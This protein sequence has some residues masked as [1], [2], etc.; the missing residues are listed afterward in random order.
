MRIDNNNV[1]K[2]NCIVVAMTFCG[3]HY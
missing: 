1:P 3:I 2:H